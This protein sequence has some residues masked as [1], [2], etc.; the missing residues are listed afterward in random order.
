MAEWPSGSA[1]SAIRPAFLRSALRPNIAACTATVISQRADET[2]G[3]PMRTIVLATILVAIAVPAGAQQ[4]EKKLPPG[5]ILFPNAQGQNVP[6]KDAKNFAQCM[7]NGR[8]LGYGDTQ[9]EPYCH[10]HYQH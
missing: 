10:E 9:S 3:L 8:K 5:Y 6:I 4:S 2:G 7:Q 1:Q